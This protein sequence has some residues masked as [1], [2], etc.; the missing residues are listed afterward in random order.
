MSVLKLEM[1]KDI[2]WKIPRFLYKK[3]LPN[4]PPEALFEYTVCRLCLFCI[5]ICMR[6]MFQSGERRRRG[7]VLN[8][9]LS[10]SSV[11]CLFSCSRGQCST[12]AVF[13]LASLLH[14]GEY[15]FKTGLFELL[16]GTASSQKWTGVESSA[17][18]RTDTVHCTV[19]LNHNGL[20]GRGLEYYQLI[21]Q[22]LWFFSEMRLF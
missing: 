13:S 7:C 5:G 12:A 15:L 1:N 22:C 19:A 14:N 8:R 6:I 20:K 9:M 11:S 17:Q 21:N 18:W 16:W 10:L 4:P 3:K 2:K